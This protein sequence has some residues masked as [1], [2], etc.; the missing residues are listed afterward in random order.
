MVCVVLIVQV[1]R[2][3]CVGGYVVCLFCGCSRVRAARLCGVL[4]ATKNWDWC[5]VG[6][7]TGWDMKL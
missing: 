4:R 1:V 2:V 5:G 6:C 7:G 3:V